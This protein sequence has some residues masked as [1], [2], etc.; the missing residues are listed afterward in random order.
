MPE[1]TT[2]EAGSSQ[3]ARERWPAGTRTDAGWQ[4]RFIECAAK[5]KRITPGLLTDRTA[6]YDLPLKLTAYRLTVPISEHRPGS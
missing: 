6:F 5:R 1:I 4:T 2:G 3:S